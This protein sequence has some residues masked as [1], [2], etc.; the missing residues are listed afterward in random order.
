MP[1]FEIGPGPGTH[2]EPAAVAEWPQEVLDAAEQAVREVPGRTSAEIA[3]RVRAILTAAG[4]R[5]PLL[6]RAK[7]LSLMRVLEAQ[8]RVR[9]QAG[10]AMVTFWPAEEGVHAERAQPGADRPSG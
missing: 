3:L 10:Q 4:Q 8:G 1:E 2:R 7:A 6:P 5:P 9:R